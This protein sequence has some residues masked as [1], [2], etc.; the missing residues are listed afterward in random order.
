MTL[1]TGGK[2][3]GLISCGGMFATE[4]ELFM[5]M[6][7]LHISE[8]NCLVLPLMFCSNSFI[9]SSCANSL[10]SQSWCYVF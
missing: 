9:A 3:A 1:K 2:G 7:N 5:E 10:P 4:K 6:G 8:D